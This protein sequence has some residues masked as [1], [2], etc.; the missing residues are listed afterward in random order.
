M[1]IRDRWY[2]DGKSTFKA[3]YK[4]I[5]SARKQI[6]IT[7]WF[8]SPELYMIREDECGWPDLR[9]DYRLDRVLKSKAEQGV[10][11]Y[12]LLWNETK[13]AVELNSLYSK[14]QLERL[15]M[16][17]HPSETITNDSN[18]VNNIK[19]IRHPVAFP[20]KWSHHQKTV[21]IDQKLAFVGGLDLCYG[22]YDDEKHELID[23]G[24]AHI[25]K[26]K[27][28]YNPMYRG[29][30]DV[31][32][33]FID[34][35]DR[36]EIHRMP[37]HDVHMCV[38]GLAARDVAYNF[39]QRWNHHK[40]AVQSPYEYLTPNTTF[41]PP[42]GNQSCQL[43]RSMSDWSGGIGAKNVENSIY[44]AYLHLISTAKHYIYIENQYFISSMANRSNNAK[45][46]FNNI[47][48]A[49][50]ERV[51][52]AILQRETFRC[53]LVI[54]CYPDGT[55]KED[56][57]IRY[58][59]KWQ[60]ETITR[61]GNSILEKLRKEFPDCSVEDYICFCSLRTFNF[62]GDRTVTEQIYVH[63]KLLIVD[64]E[65]CIIGTA[66]INDRSMLGDRDSEIAVLVR[67]TNLID[68]TMNDEPYRAAKFA[69]S[70]RCH[71]W[72]EHL[73][74][75]DVSTLS[76]PTSD[77]TYYGKWLV[78]AKKNSTIYREVFGA[79]KT[80]T[81]PSSITDNTDISRMK[82]ELVQEMVGHLVMFDRDF[83]ADS[84]LMPSKTDLNLL[85][86]STDIFT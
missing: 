5:L 52:K 24:L 84:S 55:F 67:D 75:K 18:T 30:T 64:D 49:I 21:V 63:S 4:A 86:A 9:E 42:S 28:Y 22:R 20:V 1:C 77:R 68:S 78:T 62:I 76:D 27:D 79:K 43:L 66:N 47:A 51:K 15:S 72:A 3:I 23:S 53:I 60:F 8:L 36:H 12:V 45:I 10:K 58:I 41:L 19:V 70:L 56:S 81:D 71:L 80:S 54:P 50:F 35:V 11:I 46:V 38:D 13:I 48:E 44:E 31:D 7:D 85:F 39:I 74:E 61:G 37:W 16:S 34:S 17:N 82:A 32:K 83:L 57:S 73:G 25:W 33:P 29:F 14:T 65:V 2:V 26:G 69:H 40:E 6:F 59:M